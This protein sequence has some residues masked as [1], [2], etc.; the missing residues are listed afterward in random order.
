MDAI[1]ARVIEKLAS[2]SQVGLEKYGV[3][4]K[5]DEQDFDVWL[6][7]LQEEL[8]DACNYIEKIKDEL[9]RQ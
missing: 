6:T 4:L 1:V 7:H 3:S 2:R 9:K 5:D 8:M